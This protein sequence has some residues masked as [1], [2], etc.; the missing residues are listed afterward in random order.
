[1]GASDLHDISD[2]KRAEQ[3]RRDFVANVSHELRTP[4]ASIRAVLE[5]LE[6]GAQNDPAAARD[7]ISRAQ[8]EVDRLTAMVAELLEL[9]RIESGEFPMAREPVSVGR[10]VM[11]AVERLRSQGDRLGV[12]ICAEVQPGIDNVLGDGAAWRA[13]VNRCKMLS[14]S[15]RQAEARVS[16]T[17]STKWSWS[18][19]R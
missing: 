9:S 6:A 4:L 1:V 19:S 15:R 2:V 10:V 16:V 3:I 17:E 7:F 11:E 8:T 18:P 12:R 5:T 14:N 13:V